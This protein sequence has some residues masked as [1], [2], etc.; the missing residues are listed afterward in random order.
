MVVAI[1]KVNDYLCRMKI[2]KLYRC[3][4]YV[5]HEAFYM[6]SLF[7]EDTIGENISKNNNET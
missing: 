1:N 7:R 3:E 5:Y 4:D 2:K 6:I